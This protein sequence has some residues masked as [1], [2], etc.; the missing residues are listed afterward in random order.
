[1]L[2]GYLYFH[3][4]PS[5]AA[6]HEESVKR[7]QNLHTSDCLRAN[8][9]TMAWGLEARV[10][11]LDK[12]FLDVAM[13]INPE[14]KMFGKGAQQEYDEDGCPKMEKYII[15]KAFD[16]S[17]DGKSILWRQKEQFSDGVGYS[18]ID[19]IKEHSAN[20]VSDEAMAG[21]KER[22]PVDTPDTKEAYFIREIFERTSSLNTPSL[23]RKYT[24][25]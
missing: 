9:S 2:L 1:T 16:V 13:T 14:E 19:G 7:V 8:K 25:S 5:P 22:W 18:W 10:P 21:A 6:F 12:A 24:G 11:F 15:R 4:A 3:A 20:S 17:P 23:L